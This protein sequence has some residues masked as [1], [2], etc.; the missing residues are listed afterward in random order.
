M[1]K[2]LAIVILLVLVGVLVRLVCPYIRSPVNAT[3]TIK[4]TGSEGT[5]SEGCCIHEV[6]YIMGSRTEVTPCKAKSQRI[7]IPLNLPYRKQK[8]PVTSPVQ[9]QVRILRLLM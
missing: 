4:I 6:R 8:S 9:R 3:F 2:R 5:E 7:R 1:G